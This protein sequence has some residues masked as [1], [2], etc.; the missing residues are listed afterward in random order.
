MVDFRYHVV[1]LISVFVALA[2]G[3]VLG[4]GPLGGTISDQ[5]DEQVEQLRIDKDELRDQLAAQDDEHAKDEAFIEASAD[6]LLANSLAQYRVAVVRLPGVADDVVAAVNDHL[7][8]SGAVVNEPVNL[9]AMWADPA[10]AAFRA[11]VAG[12]MASALGTTVQG[13]D[14]S[15]QVAMLAE[16][17][18]V[19]LTGTSEVDPADRSDRARAAQDVLTSG[20]EPLVQVGEIGASDLVLVLTPATEEPVEEATPSADPTAQAETEQVAAGWVAMLSALGSS[21]PVVVGGYAQTSI[22]LL[23]QLRTAATVTTVDGLDT[24]VG[25]ITVPLALR[26]VAAGVTGGGYGFGEGA[27]AVLPEPVLLGPPAW[28]GAP[29]SAAGEPTGEPSDT[30]GGA[31]SSASPTEE[32]A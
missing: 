23:P 4:A 21:A 29:D 14:D 10:Q 15:A 19:A 13:S 22:D 30:E 1:S 32:A 27:T 16:G 18:L 9:T 20:Q 17:L 25:Q 24:S 8:Q 3:I 31:E 12:A 7:A 6:Q 11:Q 5:L 2:I 28:T 26:S